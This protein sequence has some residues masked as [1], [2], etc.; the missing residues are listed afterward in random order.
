MISRPAQA[1]YRNADQLKQRKL[2]LNLF[3][4]VILE[5]QVESYGPGLCQI[6]TLSASM[7]SSALK[8]I[9]KPDCKEPIFYDPTA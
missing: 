9:A 6:M 8:S 7:L 4:L 2:V 1:Q 5:L 3:L